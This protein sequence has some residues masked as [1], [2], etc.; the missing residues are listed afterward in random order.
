MSTDN[1]VSTD[2]RA[3]VPGDIPAVLDLGAR[4]RR[5][6]PPT[7]RRPCACSWTAT[8]ARSMVAESSGQIAGSVIAGWDGWRGSVYRLA[9][10]PAHRR[11]GSGRPASPRGGAAPQS[12]RGHADAR[13]RRG[14][15]LPRRGLLGVDGLGAPERA[16]SL[17]RGVILRRGRPAGRDRAARGGGSGRRS[18]RRGPPATVRSRRRCPPRRWGT[19]VPV[20]RGAPPGAVREGQQLLHPLFATQGSS[21]IL[22]SKRSTALALRQ[23][24]FTSTDSGAILLATSGSLTPR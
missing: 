9:V 8:P 21:R 6:P 10:A 24:T 13:H 23:W 17:H 19:T 4:R 7:A 1:P 18:R 11:S 15:G 12:T 5:P 2:V 14:L 22:L 20:A 16:A 3:A